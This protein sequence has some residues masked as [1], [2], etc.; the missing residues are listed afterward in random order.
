[1]YETTDTHF[2]IGCPNVKL[3]FHLVGRVERV[4][5]PIWF[6]LF[7]TII[8]RYPG[9]RKHLLRIL[10]C[11]ATPTG[12]YH[13]KESTQGDSTPPRFWLY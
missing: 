5:T 3:R 13:I 9:I 8:A 12:V 10:D 6:Y 2:L 1:M 11:F 4:L 7:Y